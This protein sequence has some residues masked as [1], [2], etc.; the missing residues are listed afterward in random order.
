MVETLSFGII[1]D[2]PETMRPRITTNASIVHAADVLKVKASIT[3]I[4][5]KS[6]ATGQEL[7]PFDGSWG[8]PGGAY[9]DWQGALR[10]IRYSRENGQP[11]LGT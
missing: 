7:K 2:A 5:T 1:G 8:A 4:P 9:D 6:I 3:W 10:G 11:F